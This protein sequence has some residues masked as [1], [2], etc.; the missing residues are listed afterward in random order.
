MQFHGVH[1]FYENLSRICVE[2]F[3]RISSLKPVGLSCLVY[4]H[5]RWYNEERKVIS[6][7]FP[8]KTFFPSQEFKNSRKAMLEWQSACSMNYMIGHLGA[9][10]WH[11]SLNCMLPVYL[12]KFGLKCSWA[13][14]QRRTPDLAAEF[15]YRLT[16]VGH[17]LK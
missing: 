2:Q 14:L 3:T 15:V 6:A 8:R 11:S 13:E 16:Y 10:L 4:Q 7:A 12:L 17:Y 9:F 1:I 5:Q